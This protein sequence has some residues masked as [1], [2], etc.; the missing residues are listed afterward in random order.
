V[1]LIDSCIRVLIRPFVRPITITCWHFPHKAR[2]R[3][4]RQK[5]LGIPGMACPLKSR[6]AYGIRLFCQTFKPY[7]MIRQIKQNL[8]S[9]ETMFRTNEPSILPGKYRPKEGA[10]GA[11]D[12]KREMEYWTIH[13]LQHRMEKSARQTAKVANTLTVHRIRF[14][15]RLWRQFS[16]RQTVCGKIRPSLANPF[17]SIYNYILPFM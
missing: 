11:H 12:C 10:C 17:R 16:P 6:P 9:L 8:I 1:F 3:I 13:V 7:Q 2:T 4:R 15:L 5:T 14:T